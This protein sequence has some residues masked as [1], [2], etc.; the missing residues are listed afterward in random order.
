MFCKIVQHNFGID[1]IL[2]SDKVECSVHVI[3]GSLELCS[4]AASPQG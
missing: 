1:L 4:R 3:Q 2:L